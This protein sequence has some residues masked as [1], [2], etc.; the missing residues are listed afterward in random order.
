VKPLPLLGFDLLPLFFEACDAVDEV[1]GE[2]IQCGLLVCKLLMDVGSS[3]CMR[4]NFNMGCI[5]LLEGNLLKPGN[6]YCGLL[7]NEQGPTTAEE[8]KHSQDRARR[9]QRPTNNMFKVWQNL[10]PFG[11]RT[12]SGTVEVLLTKVVNWQY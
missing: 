5:F 12:I 6:P 10:A 9:R 4:R 1:N 11:G 3:S 7:T 8:I 2:D